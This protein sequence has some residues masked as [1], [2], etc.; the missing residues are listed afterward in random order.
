MAIRISHRRPT[1][2]MERERMRREYLPGPGTGGPRDGEGI[3]SDKT[4]RPVPS[5]QRLEGARAGSAGGEVVEP[6]IVT[7]VISA[8]VSPV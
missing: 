1:G 6:G 5:G 3:A 4:V 2:G 7:G 8:S